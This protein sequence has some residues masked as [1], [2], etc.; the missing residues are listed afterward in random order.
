MY[1]K[2]VHLISLNLL[3][4]VHYKLVGQW[5][6]TKIPSCNSAMH[7]VASTMWRLLTPLLNYLSGLVIPWPTRPPDLTPLNFRLWIFGK[8]HVY[9]PPLPKLKSRITTLLGVI[10]VNIF[11]NIRQELMYRWEICR[12]TKGKATS[13][14][15]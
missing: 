10:D 6:N 9:H 3:I 14:I 13:E 12:V 11:T 1:N 5:E 7:R 15:C 8:D 4:Q 2:F